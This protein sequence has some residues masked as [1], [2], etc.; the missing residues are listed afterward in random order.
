MSFK[1]NQ[2]VQEK[3]RERE[4]ETKKL[5][6]DKLLRAESYNSV[7]PNSNATSGGTPLPDKLELFLAL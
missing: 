3:E 1:A 6:E 4:R 7:P 5:V 2:H